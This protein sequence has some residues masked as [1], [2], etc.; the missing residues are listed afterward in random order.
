LSWSHG[1][2]WE[3]KEGRRLAIA[4][5]IIFGWWS[6][7]PRPISTPS[8]DKGRVVRRGDRQVDN[9]GNCDTE[10]E[11]LDKTKKKTKKVSEEGWLVKDS[12]K[13]DDTKRQGDYGG[14]QQGRGE[15]YYRG[16]PIK[17]MYGQYG[18]SSTPII[19]GGHTLSS[20]EQQDA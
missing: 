17:R 1:P 15:R 3:D 18:M 7:I 11:K 2:W 10:Q 9:A 12:S 8:D 6:R 14:C 5:D 13:L 19:C 16:H 4:D 20:D